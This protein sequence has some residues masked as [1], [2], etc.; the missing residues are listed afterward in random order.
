ML[1]VVLLDGYDSTIETLHIMFEVF[2]VALNLWK[3]LLVLTNN[4]EDV[5]ISH[6]KTFKVSRGFSQG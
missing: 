1:L 3:D 4:A 2:T 6:G 5:L